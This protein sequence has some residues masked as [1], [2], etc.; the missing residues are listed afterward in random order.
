MCGYNICRVM[1]NKEYT[2]THRTIADTITCFMMFIFFV[3]QIYVI[4]GNTI[5][6]FFLYPQIVGYVIVLLSC[7]IYHEILLLYCCGMAYNTN[8]EIDKR[9]IKEVKRMS[10]SQSNL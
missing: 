8:V 10:T 6:S 7:L 5:D 9:G 3:V 1:T 4:K 2:P